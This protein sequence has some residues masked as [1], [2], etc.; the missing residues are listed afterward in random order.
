M[1]ENEDGIPGGYIVSKTLRDN[2][3]FNIE[4]SIEMGYKF[5]QEHPPEKV[6][7]MIDEEN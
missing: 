1:E 5:F 6:F 2:Q 7:K 3:E 4:E